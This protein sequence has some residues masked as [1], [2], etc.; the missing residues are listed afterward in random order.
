MEHEGPELALV[1]R[2]LSEAPPE[3]MGE[4]PAALVAALV[5][6]ALRDLGGEGLTARTAAALVSNDAAEPG[7]NRRRWLLLVAWLLRDRA[8]SSAAHDAPQAASRAHVWLANDLKALSEVLEVGQVFGDAD[9]REEVARRA[10]AA[11]GLRPRGETREQAEDRLKTLDSIE[12]QRVI[13]EARRAQER[14]R[15]IREEMARKA[16]AEAAAARYGR[17]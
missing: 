9:R 3:V 11:L 12:R 7:R 8:F 16:A 10:L 1:T 15:L 13:L 5:S 2:R 4:A 17:E 14:A 6:D